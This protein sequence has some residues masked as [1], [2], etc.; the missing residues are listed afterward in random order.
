MFFLA[1][2][3]GGRSER[4]AETESEKEGFSVGVCRWKCVLGWMLGSWG[5]WI[6]V[7]LRSR[8]IRVSVGR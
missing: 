5:V 6:G 3:D 2:N 7:G 4:V 8:G 1:G